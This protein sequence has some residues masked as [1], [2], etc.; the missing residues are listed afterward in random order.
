MTHK[1]KSSKRIETKCSCDPNS[2]FAFKWSTT[3]Q[4]QGRNPIH[5][6]QNPQSNKICLSCHSVLPNP[7]SGCLFVSGCFGV[8]VFFFRHENHWKRKT[9]WVICQPYVLSHEKIKIR[10]NSVFLVKHIKKS[11]RAVQRKQGKADRLKMPGKKSIRNY[12]QLFDES[13]GTNTI[14]LWSPHPAGVPGNKT[15]HR[16]HACLWDGGG[17]VV[18][19]FTS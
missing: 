17:G 9:I 1:E 11:I 7:I 5:I 15:P 14:F 16:A 13:S 12:F 18:I 4:Q 10:N 3:S 19:G 8:H 2:S 6:F